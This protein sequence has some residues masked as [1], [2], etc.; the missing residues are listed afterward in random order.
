MLVNDTVNNDTTTLFDKIMK[1]VNNEEQ[2][3]DKLIENGTDPFE[4]SNTT[5]ILSTTRMLSSGKIVVMK[6]SST[7]KTMKIGNDN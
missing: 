5:R 7:G 1:V 4:D 6:Q 3:M 2:R